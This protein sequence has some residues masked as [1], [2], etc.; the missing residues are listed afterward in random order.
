VS[1]SGKLL[2]VGLTLVFL[3]LALRNVDLTAVWQAIVAADYRWLLPAAAFVSAGYLI[4]TGRWQSI[5]WPVL[6]APY[7]VCFRCL[8][9]GFAANNVLPARVG[10]VIRAYSLRQKTGTSAT[11]GVAT[12]VVERVFDG[13]TLL[14]LMAIALQVAAIPADDERLRLVEAVSIAIFATALVV[15][16]ALL[17]LRERALALVA[18]LAR[19]LPARFEA[20][21]QAMAAS[22][23]VGLECMQR[24][25][26][27]VRIVPLS[28]LVWL[29]EAAAYGCVARAFSVDLTPPQF[30]SAVLFLTV[31]VNLGIMVPSAPGFI[32][33]FQFFA[34][35]ALVPFGVAPDIA[36]GLAVV[37]HALQYG[38]VTGAGL[39]VMW[40]EHLSLGSLARTPVDTPVQ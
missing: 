17:V 2:G 18:W 4:R 27:L 40:R 6:R 26:A 3:A 7:W 8:I 39:V 31:F 36:F 38:L 16:I 22:F 12:V 5:L 32:G 20:R 33:T 13:V 28:V 29:C 14:A 10:E 11:L 15:L 25:G 30:V 35:L 34:R 19:P 24:P 1:R 9:L 23:I 21:V 37:A